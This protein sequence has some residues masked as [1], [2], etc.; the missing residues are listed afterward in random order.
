[1]ESAI[2]NY[3]ELVDGVASVE[4]VAD[5]LGLDVEYVRAWAAENELP[6]VGAAFAFRVEHALALHEEAENEDDDD[7]D[8]DAPEEDD[9]DSNTVTCESCDEEMPR[10]ATF[11]SSCGELLDQD[12]AA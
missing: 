12:D 10:D 6:R 1:M 2:S 4:D 5:L 8:D 9:D 11:C 3:F 7:F